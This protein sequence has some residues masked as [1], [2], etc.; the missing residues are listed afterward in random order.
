MKWHR[1]NLRNLLCIKEILIILIFFHCVSVRPNLRS[2][3][4]Y[5]V[6]LNQW[7]ASLFTPESRG[8]SSMLYKKRNATETTSACLEQHTAAFERDLCQLTEQLKQFVF[9]D[10]YGKIQDEKAQYYRTMVQRRFPNSRNDVTVTRIR[11][12]L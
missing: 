10:I 8:K 11:L 1:I 9:L 6:Q 4:K 12:W 2:D 5:T 7:H 3:Y